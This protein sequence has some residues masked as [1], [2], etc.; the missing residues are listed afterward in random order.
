[1]TRPRCLE[2]TPSPP[3]DGGGVALI[4]VVTVFLL[5][6]SA[7]LAVDVG[8]WYNRGEKLQTAV[9][10]AAVAAATA[11]SSGDLVAAEAAGRTY[12]TSNGVTGDVTVTVAD[13][14]LGR[15]RVTVQDRAALYFGRLVLPRLSV[16]RSAIAEMGLCGQ[17]CP[18]IRETVLEPL[19]G[20][21][22][23]AS[24][25]GF[26]PIL[27]GSRIFSINHHEAAGSPSL[28]CVDRRTNDTCPGYPKVLSSVAGGGIGDISTNYKPTAVAAGG[29]IY[30][31]AQ[32]AAD[33]GVGC[34]DTTT[35]RSCGYG[36]L[37]PL[38]RGD[39]KYGTRAGGPVYVLG[40]LIA[41]TDDGDVHCLLPISLQRCPGYPQP[42]GVVLAG[43][44]PYDFALHGGESRP[45]E[46][47]AVGS[48]VYAAI[49]YFAGVQRVHG[50]QL[51]CFDVSADRPC[52][53]WAG[54]ANAV[55]T[56]TFDSGEWN[57]A[58][59]VFVRYDT[60]ARPNGICV[61]RPDEH[62]CVD[63]DGR[64]P[65]PVA[66]LVPLINGSRSDMMRPIHLDGRTFFPSRAGGTTCWDWRT[67]SS[68]GSRSWN[69]TADYAY[70][71]D[72]LC[73][74]GTG[75]TVKF[76]SF[77]PDLRTVG[78]GACSRSITTVT[79]PRCSCANGQT[80]WGT[81]SVTG[82]LTG[83]GALVLVVRAPDGTV[84]QRTD[85][86]AAGGGPVPLGPVPAGV[87]SL[88]VTVEVT[89]LDGVSSFVPGNEPQ[90][91]I[92]FAARARLVG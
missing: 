4:V 46:P 76:W 64:N 43:V 30:Y 78:S 14:G 85:L 15:V 39:S 53:G 7:A 75:H 34:F 3:A 83:V 73:I 88:D 31:A 40:K 69:G 8:V 63:L 61:H 52:P 67:N 45:I 47:V 42:G 21:Q 92:S 10:A 41:F 6:L 87:Q 28:V 25:D 71:T 54:G 66:G 56:V 90:L 50:S 58:G 72:G 44:P 5:L 59:A 79:V 37:A 23:R 74:F 17:S 77:S 26:E 35:D 9:D 1:M 18:V 12:V 2:P 29:R 13:A 68:C 57:G 81:A 22:T 24:G 91:E 84:L 86:L 33:V 19:A 32:R 48:R 80:T 11:R 55:R 60:S 20:I 65:Q 49:H 82:D 38:A 16:T 36:T 70:A 51:Q 27:V 89:M 62:V